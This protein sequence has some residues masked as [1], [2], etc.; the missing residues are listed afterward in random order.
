MKI[1]SAGTPI[2]VLDLMRGFFGSGTRDELEGG[3]RDLLNVSWCRLTG[4][5][6][7]ALYAILEALKHHSDRLEVVLPAYTAP[8]LILPIR[9][10]GL[11][12]VLCEVSHQTLNAGSAEMLNCVHSGT[13]AVMPVHMF[14]LPTDVH[15]ISEQ[16]RGS[17]T[18]VIEDA[19]SAMGGRIG[20]RLA[21]TFGDVGFYSFNR[22]KNLSTL[23]GGAIVSSQEGLIPDMEK[24]LNA[25]PY[26]GIQRRLRM[27]AY[28][29]GLVLAVRPLGYTLLYPVISKFKYTEL[30]TDFDTLAYTHFQARIGSSLL[31]RA[32]QIEQKRIENGRYLHLAL[33][34][35]KGIRLAEIP[36]DCV[37]VHNQFPVLLRNE[38]TRNAALRA[39]LQTGLEATLLYPDPIHRIYADLWDGVGPDPFPNA[40]DI[41]RRLLLLPVHPLVP[42]VA[43]ARAVKA[44]RET[45]ENG[46]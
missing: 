28:I 16:L 40:T 34:D 24:A 5:G 20:G 42:R 1:P 7:S 12:P 6:T 10:A 32:E 4:S 15:A 38:H 35:V 22:G 19:C 36:E 31:V 11:R 46:E 23:S 45:V 27:V 9:K 44:I 33:N 3:L 29:L 39:I 8:S 30:H 17:G 18:T 14:G 13:L 37:P 2:S 26:P 25:F 41:A 21:G 43:L